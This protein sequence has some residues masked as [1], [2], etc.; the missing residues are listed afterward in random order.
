MLESDSENTV[1]L[2]HGYIRCSFLYYQIPQ[3][4]P[5]I[6]GYRGNK[7][8][9]ARSAAFSF[10]NLYLTTRA[11]LWRLPPNVLVLLPPIPSA[12]KP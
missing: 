11:M 4:T 8:V 2:D 1:S 5:V 7:V 3:R 12:A 6:I 9:S 10:H